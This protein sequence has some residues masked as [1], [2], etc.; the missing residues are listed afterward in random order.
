MVMIMLD[1]STDLFSGRYLIGVIPHQIDLLLLNRPVEP[2][3]QRIVGGTA[4]PGIGQLGSQGFKKLLGD[5][6][7]IGRAPIHPKLGLGLT[8]KRDPL[9]V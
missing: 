6:R 2:L 1:V 5:P 9:V 8:V 3:G 4:D 7:G